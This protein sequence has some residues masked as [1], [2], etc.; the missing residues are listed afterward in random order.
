[1]AEEKSESATQIRK[2]IYRLSGHGKSL[3]YDPEYIFKIPEH[4][5]VITISDFRYRIFNT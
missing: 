2:P 3:P 5:N 1:M 4:T